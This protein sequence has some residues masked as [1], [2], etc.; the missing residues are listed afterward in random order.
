M[1]KNIKTIIWLLVA[2][3]GAAAIAVV[4]LNRGES[5]SAMWF[6]TAA[7]C[8]YAIAYRF[9]AAWIAATV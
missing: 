2:L 8:V 1:H 6:I 9:Y 3:L 5:I 7:F 4:A